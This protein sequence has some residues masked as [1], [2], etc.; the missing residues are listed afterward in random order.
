MKQV[1]KFISIRLGWFISLFYCSSIRAFF[2]SMR[3]YI[4]TGIITRRC[5][6]WGANSNIALG[7]RITNPQYISV[8]SNSVFLRDTCLTATPCM[9]DKSPVISIGNHCRFGFSN[10]ISA[11]NNITIGDHVLTGSYVLISDNAH[12]ESKREELDIPPLERHLYSKGGIHIGNNVWIG[13]KVSILPGVH[14]GENSIIGANSLVTRDIP[15]N[16]IAAGI[17]ATVIRKL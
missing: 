4:H 16:C 3:A 6:S 9:Q 1:I 12:G 2:E 17:P 15:R 13:D 11:I 8:G 5:K 7:G 14:I 10:H